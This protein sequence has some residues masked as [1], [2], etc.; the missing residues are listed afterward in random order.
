MKRAGCA[1]LPVFQPGIGHGG[2]ALG[3]NQVVGAVKGAYLA[4][5]NERHPVTEL[6]RVL[7]V[8][9]GQQDGLPPGFFRQDHILHHA[10]VGRVKAV[11]GLVQAEQGRVVQQ[12]PDEIQ[13][14]L[15]A[16][17][18]LGYPLVPIPL[19]AHRL[20]KLVDRTGLF[21]IQGCEE[22][23]IFP[24]RQFL[25][26]GGEFKVHPDVL[27]K[28]LCAL[29]AFHAVHHGRA[30]VTGQHPRQHFLQGALPGSRGA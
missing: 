27:V 7:H 1:V 14:G 12:C 29:P 4:A 18:I 21:L 20:Q 16:L 23:Q 3:H 10:A 19:Q 15:H 24:G 26:Q 13:P 11:C 17:G 22:A 5:H 6:G 2:R 8:V 25:I 28:I 9:G 30:L